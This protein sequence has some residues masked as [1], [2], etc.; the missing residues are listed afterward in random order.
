[1]AEL[2]FALRT[3]RKSPVFTLVAVLSL[4]LGIGA[5]AAIFTLVDQILIRLLPVHNPAELVQMRIEGGRFG[6][7]SGD[8]VHTF[9][10]P[11]YKFLRDENT[12]FAGLA[13]QRLEQASLIANDRGEM[14]SVGLVSGT[15]FGVLGVKPH[16]GRLI[17][18]DDDRLKNGHPVVVLQYHFWQNRFV[19]DR[20]IIGSTV[21][22]NGT[23]FTVIGVAAPEFE[24]TAAG[25]PTNLWVPVMMKTAITPTWDELENDRYSWFYLFG[26]LKPGVSLQQAQASLRVLYRQRQHEELK[27]PMFQ[28]FPDLRERFLKQTFL[29]VPASQG[30]SFL[31]ERFER[32]LLVLQ[33]LVG[34]VLLIACANVAN[35]LLARAAARQKEIAIRTAL[36]A[37]RAQIIRQLLIESIVLASAG[38]AVGILLSTWLS[39]GLLML[40]PFDPANLSLST[41]PDWR[42]LGFTAAVTL[43][44]AILF[45]LAPAWHASRV[46]PATTLKEEGGAVVG[47]TGHV[48]LRKA[49]VALQ[50]GLSVLMLAG[51]GLFVRSL[52]NLKSVDLG[53]RTEN[54]I[55]FGVRPGTVY[56]ANR[57]LQLVRTLMDS[58]AAVPGV[59]AVG[60]NSSRLFTGGRWDTSI[61]L[62]GA[63][64]KTGEQPFSYFNSV[65]PGYFDALGIPVK[66]GRDFRWSDWGG[67]SVAL[68]NETFANE[69]LPGESPVGRMMAQGRA[70]TPNTEIIGV[71]GNARYEDVRGKVPIQTFVLMGGGQYIQPISGVTVYARS[72]RDPRQL[73]TALRGAVRKTD[74]NLVISDMRTM[75]EQVNMRISN[76]RILSFLSTGFALLATLLAVIGLYGVLAFVVERRTREIGIRMALG[77]AQANVIRMVLHEMTAVIACGIL[78]GAL[79]ALAAGQYVQA[80]LFGV[81]ASDPAVLGASVL[82]LAAAAAA[83][84]FVPAWRASKIDPMRA[85]RHD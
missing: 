39:G 5:N 80:Q 44:T 10:Y 48:G 57:K 28:K 12:V 51:A 41:S 21:R 23:P 84:G 34:I 24:G 29:L 11:L 36:G 75:D 42:I 78:V 43:L 70:N 19:G 46:T 68:V 32:P 20:S 26:R 50:V 49:L 31:R 30:Q 37:S 79:A 27:G 74:P 4:A 82:L 52:Q 33:W 58:L 47:G 9:S 60:A 76:E 61:T 81:K 72:D 3:F 8:G 45:G 18:P 2:Q 59:K 13:G 77:A 35:L 15:F 83:A 54:V 1:M 16:L 56:D 7:N 55:M 14:I 53:L 63:A 65:T 25:I 38:G 73:M 69:Y 71:F 67:K 62:P 64:V 85:L 66:L 40:L 17:T 6:S 22:L